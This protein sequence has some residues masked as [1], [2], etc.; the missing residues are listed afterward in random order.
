MSNPS[1]LCGLT[2]GCDTLPS[3]QRLC[4]L[5]GSPNAGASLKRDDHTYAS[6]TYTLVVRVMRESGDQR[7]VQTFYGPSGMSRDEAMLRAVEIGTAGVFDD[8]TYYPPA[9]VLSVRLSRDA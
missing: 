6:D 9:R 3:G 4:K 7:R 1:E 5:A 2:C 8:L